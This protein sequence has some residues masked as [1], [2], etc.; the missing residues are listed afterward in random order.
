MKKLQLFLILA[1]L[2]IFIN[3]SESLPTV[4]DPNS[5]ASTHISPRYIEMSYQETGS[6][7]FVTAVL[8]DYRAFD[9][10]G[11]VIVIFTAGVAT[12]LTLRTYKDK[13]K[14]KDSGVKEK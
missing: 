8:G 7:N 1:V 14:E 12:I 10:L 2:F 9:T 5:P 11:E 6:K 13:D 3:S 4:G